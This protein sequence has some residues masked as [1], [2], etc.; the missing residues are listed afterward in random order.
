M[1]LLHYQPV[2]DLERGPVGVEALI[3]LHHPKRGVLLP[4]AFS[5]SLDHPTLGKRIGRLVLDMAMTQAELWQR[6]GLDL[7]IS[8]NIGPRH[9]LE[10]GFPGDL[11]EALNAHPEIPPSRLM[12]E[13][14]ET[15][16]MLDFQRT[17]QALLACGR[18]GVGVALDDFGTG[19]APLTWLQ[20]LPAETVKIDRSFVREMPHDPRSHAI[21]SGMVDTGR[22][23]GLEM[24]AAGVESPSQVSLLSQMACARLQGYA[25]ARPMPAEEVPGWFR[26]C[27]LHQQWGGVLAPL[28]Q[29]CHA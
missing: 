29:T 11:C 2:L 15:A 20:K 26:S 5:R 17:K 12:V 9:L 19:N 21:V 13:I 25:I 10:T 3:R 1:L 24:V 23:A 18:L 8:V 16:P 4:A 28:S 6:Q 7:R 14:T 22:M 27:A